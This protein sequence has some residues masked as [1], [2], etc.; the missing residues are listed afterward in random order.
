MEASRTP[1]VDSSLLAVGERSLAGSLVGVGLR[2]GDLVPRRGRPEACAGSV[3][4]A[5]GRSGVEG[6]GAGS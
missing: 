5:G 1:V 6:V 2:G 3:A 4:G